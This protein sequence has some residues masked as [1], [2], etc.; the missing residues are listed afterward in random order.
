MFSKAPTRIRQPKIPASP[1]HAGMKLRKAI[2]RLDKL[3]QQALFAFPPEAMA[4]PVQC[5]S[6]DLVALGTVLQA[7]L[8]SLTELEASRLYYRT[9]HPEPRR[10]GSA[11]KHDH[12]E[13]PPDAAL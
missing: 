11:A 10:S 4:I 7:A 13:E 5:T 3:R 1:T 8:K 2:L 6:E 12:D 9:I